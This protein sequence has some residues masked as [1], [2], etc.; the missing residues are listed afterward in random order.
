M[1]R[2]KK[3]VCAVGIASP[4]IMG[5]LPDLQKVVHESSLDFRKENILILGIKSPLPYQG[6]I[7]PYQILIIS[8]NK[9]FGH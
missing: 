8:G 3:K 9:G 4:S 5:D 6:L 7:I 2:K 1:V